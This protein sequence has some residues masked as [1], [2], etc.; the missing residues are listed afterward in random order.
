MCFATKNNIDSLTIKLI[1]SEIDASA[2]ERLELK[3]TEQFETWKLT[4]FLH[5]PV[6]YNKI[7]LSNE[8][9]ATITTIITHFG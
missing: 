7:N 9:N 8:R 1:Q 4:L 3:I 5:I 6:F 2:N